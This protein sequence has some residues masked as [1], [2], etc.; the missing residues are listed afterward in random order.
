MNNSKKH[1]VAE[2]NARTI[3]TNLGSEIV[4]MGPI[5]DCI[6]TY[7]ENEN[8]LYLVNDE[9]DYDPTF[10]DHWGDRD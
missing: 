6:E 10:E 4:D 5:Y 2:M 9:Y 3:E 7:I 1:K 8:G